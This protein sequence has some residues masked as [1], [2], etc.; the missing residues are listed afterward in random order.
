MMAVARCAAIAAMLALVAACSKSPEKQPPA[1]EDKGSGVEAPPARRDTT[2]WYR[3]VLGEKQGTVVPFFLELTKEEAI[4][5][6]GADRWRAKVTSAPPNLVAKFEVLHTQIEATAGADGVLEGVWKASSKS[7]G[8]GSLSF[9]AEP[10]AAPDPKLRFPQ[11]PGPDPSG[12]WKVQ[13]TKEDEL[14]RLVIAR[15]ES[16]EVTG[17]IEFQTGNKALLAGNQD[18]KT[19]RMSAFDGSSPYLI[20]AELD[21][22]ATTFAGS[23]TAGHTFAWKEQLSGEKTD[24]AFQIDTRLVGN[25]PKLAVPQLAKPP[26]A[27]NPVIVELGGSWCPAC[28]SASEKLRELSQKYAKDGLQVLMLAYEF[29]DETEYNQR[30]AALFKEKYKIPWEVVAIDGGLDKYHD[31]LPKE[32]ESIDASGFPIT[33]FVARDGGIEGFHAGFPPKS[34]GALHEH[35]VAEYDRLAAKIAA[36][37]KRR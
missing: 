35:T 12:T 32:L 34:W 25:R 37:P 27:G 2:G 20:V 7:W 1:P 29:T 8:Q 16:G 23:W 18:G 9:R 26:Y 17:T 6:T 24:F 15:A 19:I 13:L 5:A 22:A 4:I 30:Q 31:I 33:I 10:I 11:S 14:A 3:A 21:D 36:S 28:G